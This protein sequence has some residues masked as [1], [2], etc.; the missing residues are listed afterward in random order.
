M[1]IKQ[2]LICVLLAGAA[3]VILD[4]AGKLLQIDFGYVPYIVGMFIFGACAGGM[5]KKA[6]KGGQ[7]RSGESKK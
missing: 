1:S 4:G 3:G 5:Q 7:K 2:T 6:E